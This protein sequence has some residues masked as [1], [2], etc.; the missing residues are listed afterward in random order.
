MTTLITHETDPRAD[1]RRVLPRPSQL[2]YISF[3][4]IQVDLQRETVTKESSPIKVSGNAYFILLVFLERPGQIVT[5][6]SLCQG[7]WPSDSEIEKYSNLNTT[8]NKLRRSL[9]DSSVKPLYIKTIP[10]RG[11]VFI[12]H[13]RAS[14]RPVEVV[15]SHTTQTNTASLNRSAHQGFETVAQSGFPS[16]VSI[17][18]L[19]LIGSLLGAGIWMAAWITYQHH[20]PS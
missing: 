4:G 14:D 12:E 18:G 10:R 11:Y 3:D 9:G 8:I 1:T 7:L 20:A 6:D 5:R 13:P 19:I 17:V 2:R 16:I 15:A